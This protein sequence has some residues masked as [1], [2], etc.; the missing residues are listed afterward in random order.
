[1]LKILQNKKAWESEKSLPAIIVGLIILSFGLIPL[2]N[3]MGTISFNLP[4]TPAGKVLSILIALSGLFLIFSGFREIMDPSFGPLLG[5]VSVILGLAVAGAGIT[6]LGWASL[7]F[8]AFI[9]SIPSNILFIII[10]FLLIVLS[11]AY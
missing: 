2:L 5:W 7:T 3:N 1:M 8:L 4:F 10:G 6:A 11:F 9:I